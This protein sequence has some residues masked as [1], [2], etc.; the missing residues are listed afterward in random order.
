MIYALLGRS[1]QVRHDAS[2]DTTMIHYAYPVYSRLEV[3]ARVH[4]ILHLGNC[5]VWTDGCMRVF[6]M[7]C[8]VLTLMPKRWESGLWR[9]YHFYS[10]LAFQLAA[11]F[12]QTV[13]ECWPRKAVR[14]PLL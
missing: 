8:L 11:S 14:L 5:H 6:L 13:R 4:F 12:V 9:L 7:T 1:R 10:L 3:P 2:L